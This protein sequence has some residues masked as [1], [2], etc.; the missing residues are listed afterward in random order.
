MLR[1]PALV[2]AIWLANLV[3]AAPL[4]V[5]VLESIHSFTADSDYHQVLLEGFDT[6]WYW[7][8]KTSRGALEETF[9]PSHV[10]IGAWLANLDRWWDGRVFLEPAR[11]LFC[12]GWSCSVA[13][14]RPCAKGRRG[15]GCRPCSPTASA[16]FL[17]C[18]ESRC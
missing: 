14:S 6:G 13:C 12:S 4:A 16:F 8:F 1:A 17:D 15:L 10:G 2:L 5:F 18:C 9:S 7:E 11:S 3:I